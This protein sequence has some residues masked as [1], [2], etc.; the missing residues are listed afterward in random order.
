MTRFGQEE[1]PELPPP[2]LALEFLDQR[3]R[4]VR[5]QAAALLVVDRLCRVDHLLHE[6]EQPLAQA[7]DAIAVCEVHL[8]Q[9][10]AADLIAP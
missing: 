10:P 9:F 5:A 6:G 3:R 1:I 4:L 8:S 7:L 2:R